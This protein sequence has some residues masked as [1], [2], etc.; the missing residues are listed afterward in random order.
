ML[1]LKKINLPF[2]EGLHTLFFITNIAS[3]QNTKGKIEKSME[4]PSDS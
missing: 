4:I 2:L 3:I 1:K